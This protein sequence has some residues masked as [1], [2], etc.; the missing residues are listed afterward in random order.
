MN[1]RVTISA[2]KLALLLLVIAGFSACADERGVL[3]PDVGP[4]FTV[5]VE[6]EC[7]VCLGGV[8]ELR[9]R[10]DGLVDGAIV[11]K[12][13]KTVIFEGS[14]APGGEFTLSGHKADGMYKNGPAFVLCR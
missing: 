12:A 11:V 13:G 2:K 14:V 4:Q 9:L 6:P 7:E 1:A 3:D 10:Y 5:M 8:T